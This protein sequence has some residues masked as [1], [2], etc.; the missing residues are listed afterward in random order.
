MKLFSHTKVIT[1]IVYCLLMA[2]AYIPKISHVRYLQD[3]WNVLFVTEQ[4]GPGNLVFHYSI[5]R[6]LRG[7]FGLIEYRFFGTN[8]VFY[9]GTALLWRFLDTA[10]IFLAFLLIWPKHWKMN[11]AIA[12]LVLVYP[13]FHEL[14]HVF[15]YQAHLFSRMCLNISILLSLLPLYISRKWGKWVSVAGALLLAQVSYGLMDIYIGMEALRIGLIAAV[16]IQRKETRQWWKYIRYCLVYLAGAAAFTYWR[17]FIFVSRRTSVDAGAM[18]SGYSSLGEKLLENVQGLGIN[19]YRLVISAFYEP[20]TVFGKHLQRSEWI[21]GIALALAASVVVVLSMSRWLRQKPK[22]EKIVIKRLPLT[23]ILIGLVGSIGGLAPV[24]FGGRDILYGITGDR[25][26]YPGSISACIL[27]VGLIWLIRQRGLRTGI[28]AVLVFLSVLTQFSNNI[29]FAKNGEQTRAAWWQMSWRAPQISPATLLTGRIHLGIL[30]EDY[31]LWGPANLIY[32]PGNREVVITAEVLDDSTLPVFLAGEKAIAERKG[33]AFEKDFANL[34]VLSKTENA[35]LHIIDGLHPEYSEGDD[36]IIRE[37]GSFS[38]LERIDINAGFTPTPRQDLFGSEPR[39]DW[40]YYFQKA[41]L[42]RQ[43]QD[44]QAVSQLGDEA[45]TAGYTP[46]DQMEW[47]VFLQAFAYTGSLH[48]EKVL[49]KVKSDA[50]SHHQACEVYQSYTMEMENTDL[51]DFH[52]QLLLS[53]C[54]ADN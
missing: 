53:V 5:D 29:I 10:A 11:L 54:T 45:L 27:I 24:I 41:Q 16:F 39:H 34:M 37:V 17:L 44:W 47:L 42:A 13:G 48:F 50:Y 32:Y 33:I 23:L 36:S 49:V 9:K 35:C 19:L 14:P 21:E 4:Q 28:V 51:E 46:N 8:L 3:D 18:L 31:T 52:R 1:I 20:L 2:L 30:D 7:Y 26:S 15:D 22:G 6:P 38:Q 40:C 43:Q 25:F 12:A